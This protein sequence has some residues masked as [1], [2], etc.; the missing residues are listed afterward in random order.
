MVMLVGLI[1]VLL[2]ICTRTHRTD[3]YLFDVSPVKL[4]H[5]ITFSALMIALIAHLHNIY[6][7]Y[8]LLIFILGRYLFRFAFL[9]IN[10]HFNTSFFFYINKSQ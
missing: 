1:I 2:E 7:P 10:V 4:H 6:I 8:K 5:S 3:D 9:F